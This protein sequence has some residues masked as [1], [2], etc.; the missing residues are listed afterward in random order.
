M[1]EA[2]ARLFAQEMADEA[3]SLGTCK[4]EV[5]V[6]Y[7]LVPIDGMPDNNEFIAELGCLRHGHSKEFRLNEMRGWKPPM[8]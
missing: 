4:I 3:T 2:Y 7:K 1:I 5:I 8:V 6:I